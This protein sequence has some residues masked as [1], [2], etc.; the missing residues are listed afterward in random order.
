YNLDAP[1]IYTNAGVYTV[2]AMAENDNYETATKEAVLT[3]SKAA[4]TLIFNSTSVAF[5]NKGYSLESATMNAIGDSLTTITYSADGGQ[6]YNLDAPPIY[7]N[8]GVYTVV[9]R[10]EN[11]NYETATK[12]AVL[13]ISKIAQTLIFNSTSV[14]FD[15]K[16]HALTL[17]TTNAIDGADITY[18]VDGTTYE[19]DIPSFAAVGSYKITARAVNANYITEEKMAI[20]TI[21]KPEITGNIIGVPKMFKYKASGKNNTIKVSMPTKNSEVI[22][23]VLP[24]QYASVIKTGPN[25][26]EVT[27]KNMEGIVKIRGKLKEVSNIYKEAQ[28]KLVR[29]VTNIC[30]SFDEYYISKGKSL[31]IPVSLYDK[32]NK[33]IDGGVKSK[34]IWQTSNAKLLRVTQ[35]GKITATSK[36]KKKT[37]VTI[38]VTAASGTKKKITVYVVPEAKKLRK[39]SFRFLNSFFTSRAKRVSVKLYPPDTENKKIIY[40]SSNPSG[41]YIDKS[42]F[43][44]IKKKGKYKITVSVGNKKESRVYEAK[45]VSIL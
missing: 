5:D 7:T 33:F 34:I 3:I 39:I 6:S 17:A 44:I 32:T 26:A 22:W 37:K 19:K 28:V 15:N 12:E 13:T 23:Q 24:T 8:A 25:T 40:K 16:S 4:Q 20:L 35:K 43:I 29:N 1:P 38:T 10:A 9:A 30:V 45:Y 18:T 41:L 2:V 27:F 21:L 31:T 11:D 14:A 36:V 42:G